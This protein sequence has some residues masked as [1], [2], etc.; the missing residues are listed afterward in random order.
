MSPLA[1]RCSQ[2][3]QFQSNG[4]N[5]SNE[6]Y[7]NQWLSKCALDHTELPCKTDLAK[8]LSP[9]CW[10]LSG[11]WPYYTGVHGLLLPSR[12]VSVFCLHV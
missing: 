8:S 2:R 12:R 11:D 6:L 3:L 10:I 4:V 5:F 7:R 9:G 1:S